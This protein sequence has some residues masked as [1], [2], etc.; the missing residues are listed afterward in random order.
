MSF[1]NENI[2]RLFSSLEDHSMPVELEQFKDM[3]DRLERIRYFRFGWKHFNIYYTIIIALSFL[4]SG[5]LLYELLKSP[6]AETN[7]IQLPVDSVDATTTAAPAGQIAPKPAQE[8]RKIFHGTKETKSSAPDTALIEAVVVSPELVPP[9][10]PV[11]APAPVP[12]KDTTPVA[13]P[14]PKVK[15]VVMIPKRDTII[16]Y[17]TTKVIKRK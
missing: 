7:I 4:F 13:K 10:A 9:P 17:D 12:V 11:L 1:D 16:K 3:E 6:A 15:K 14:A 2:D 8:K 5:Y